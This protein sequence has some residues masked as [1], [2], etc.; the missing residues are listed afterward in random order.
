METHMVI[1]N[2]DRVKKE[3]HSPN[4]HLMPTGSIAGWPIIDPFG[5]E[6]YV[7][8]PFKVEEGRYE[9]GKNVAMRSVLLDK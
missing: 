6:G 8:V 1:L 3:F 5:F 2:F 9:W 4:F 7:F